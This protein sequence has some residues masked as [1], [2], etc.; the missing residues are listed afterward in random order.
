MKSLFLNTPKTK[1][2]IVF[3]VLCFL[4]CLIALEASAM[5]FGKYSGQPTDAD[6]LG[7]G[8]IWMGIG[9]L[10]VSIPYLVVISVITPDYNGS[11]SLFFRSRKLLP[12]LVAILIGMPFLLIA[13]SSIRTLLSEFW[14]GDVGVV[15]L[16][17]WTFGQIRATVS[18]GFFRRF[19]S[20]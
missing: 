10:I 15:I 7:L 19:Q 8:M 14:M 9:G 2:G 20:V 16:S 5:V 6:S 18:S 3:L 12:D 17:L 11:V 4:A 1:K 13:Y